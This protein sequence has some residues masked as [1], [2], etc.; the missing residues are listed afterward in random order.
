MMEPTVIEVEG[1]TKSYKH[2]SALRGLD[3]K[4]PRGSVCGFLGRNGAGKTTTLRILL[5]LARA[6]AGRAAVFGLPCGH[7]AS[8][9]EIRKRT[10]YVSER[11]QLYPYMT[12]DQVIRFTKPFYPKWNDRLEVHYRHLFELDGSRRIPALSKGA[13]S[14]LNL[15]LALCRGAD[16]LILDEPTDGL[17]PAVTEDVL[18]ALV[19]HVAEEGVT[20]FFSS[21]Q[22]Q[23]VEQIA[24]WV[25]LIHEGRTVVNESLE[26]LR[27]TCRRVQMVF[28]SN[29]NEA[30]ARLAELGK[31]RQDGRWASVLVRDGGH[32]AVELGRA[33]GAKSIEVEPV[34]LKELF[35][36]SVKR[37]SVKRETEVM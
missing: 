8:S 20:L 2:V 12:V 21:H 27:G 10:G 5:G 37:D 24:D 28:E 16:L 23:E 17:D 3:L 19:S 14:K 36:D 18:Q 9:I 15:L 29:V 22:L 1:L 34:S 13:L 31:V 30:A 11:K 4:I 7:E 6:D 35:L 26:D 25:C 32:R 33:L